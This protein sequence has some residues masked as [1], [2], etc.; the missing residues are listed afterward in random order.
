MRAPR[1]RVE[2]SGHQQSGSVVLE[3]VGTERTPTAWGSRVV[4][5]WRVRCRCGAEYERTSYALA[6]SKRNGWRLLCPRCI[7]HTPRPTV[8]KDSVTSPVADSLSSRKNS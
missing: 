5:V 1:A 4:P 3:R 8:G 2:W 7:K 6:E